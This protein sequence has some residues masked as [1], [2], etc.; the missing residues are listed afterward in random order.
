MESIRV[1]NTDWQPNYTKEE[2]DHHEQ[3]GKLEDGKVQSRWQVVDGD[4]KN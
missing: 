4:G 2:I 1:G 3:D